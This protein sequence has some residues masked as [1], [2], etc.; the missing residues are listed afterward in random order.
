MKSSFSV[1]D[2]TTSVP[3]EVIISKYRGIGYAFVCLFLL[4]FLP[5]ITNSRPSELNA[6]N[7]AFYLSLWELISSLPIFIS[8]LRGKSK[9]IFEKDVPLDIKRYTYQV[10][11]VTGLLFTLATFLYVF[12]LE[13]AGTVSAAIAMQ[14]Y[15]PFT[16]LMEALVFN[17]R[18]SRIE[19]VFTLFLVGG[20][21]YLGTLGTLAI[22]DFSVWFILALLV[23]LLWAVAHITIKRTIRTSPISPNQITFFR[24]LIASVVL[25]TVASF[26]S[27]PVLVIQG[28]FNLNFQKFAILM[29]TVYYLELLFWYYSIRHVHL[30]VSSSITA[31]SPVLTM[32]LA[33]LIL[34]EQV[35]T[36]Q[37]IASGIV[38]VSLYG[39]LV[40]LRD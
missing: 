19:L 12:S 16:I 40:N 5:I 36:Y 10:M 6:L 33:V 15:L 9:G 37:L 22:Q 32:I 13:K 7:F 35:L 27:S 2:T 21:Y 38:I 25:F 11:L 31:L 26:A 17:K 14:A 3:S 28:L 29:G 4:G 34:K 1:I 39:L 8:E 23:P 18:K 24:V 30:S 20:L